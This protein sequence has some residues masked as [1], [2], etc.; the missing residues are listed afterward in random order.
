[1][2]LVDWLE[3]TYGTVVELFYAHG[4]QPPF[5]L[6]RPCHCRSVPLLS[7]V[8][9]PWLAGLRQST[10]TL[11]STGF[12]V[13][14]DTED[15][16]FIEY[17]VVV[18]L[19][20]DEAAQSPSAM[21]VVGAPRHFEYGPEAGAAGSFR[22]DVFHASVAPQ[23]TNEHLKIAYFFRASHKG[24]RRAKRGLAALGVGADDEQS[25]AQRRRNVTQEL[26]GFAFEAQAKLPV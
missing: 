16:S 8:F 19:T 12:D 14:Q 13:H 18:K 17:T 2:Y 24:E 25:L 4:T 11:K 3:E 5:K 23:G 21:R 1:M 26:N 6:H 20:P 7:P 9:E 22:A 10:Q 15:F